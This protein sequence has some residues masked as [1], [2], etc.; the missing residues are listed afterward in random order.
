MHVIRF[1]G[2][3]HMKNRNIAQMQDDVSTIVHWKELFEIIP[4]LNS[5]L[6]LRG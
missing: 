2:A 5:S 3:S 4:S 6:K 1:A